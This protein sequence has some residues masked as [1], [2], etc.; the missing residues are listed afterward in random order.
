[1]IEGRDRRAFAAVL[2]ASLPLLL[3][4]PAPSA[5]AQGDPRSAIQEVLDARAEAVIEGDREAFLAPVADGARAFLR[6][7]ELLFDGLQS[8]PLESYELEA[9]WKGAGDLARPSDRRAH[10]DADEVSI[11]MTEERYALSDVDARPAREDLFL[12]FVREGDEWSIADDND[13][14]EVGLF[15]ARHLWDDGPVTVRDTGRF[16]VIEHPCEGA[17]SE[18]HGC[19]A[20]TSNFDEILDRAW[21]NAEER[22]GA[23]PPPDPVAVLAPG[24]QDELSRLIQATYGLDN[25]LAFATS[26]VDT[27]QGIEFV[28]HRILL[29]WS[30]L[31]DASDEYLE[32]ILTHELVHVGTR[33]LAGPFTPIFVD[34][35]IAELVARREE[36][37]SLQAL[38]DAVADGTFDRRLPADHEF[39]TGGPTAIF[40]S[41]KESQSAIAYMIDR[42][43]EEAFVDFYESLGARRLDAGTAEYHVDRALRDSIGIGFGR[44]ERAWADS[45]D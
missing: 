45:I 3:N 21:T 41:Y 42:Y 17:G 14:D 11:V 1:M 8:L 2:L 38:E 44:F 27:T 28:G 36:V 32:T 33:S 43:G 37:A 40:L 26:T 31:E 4:A 23:A 12:T 24:T 34:E 29:N 7:Q 35:G 15:S 10:Q 19:A 20:L 25:F 13:L 22:L 9:D 6:R 5:S 16:S 30:Q 39:R 18:P